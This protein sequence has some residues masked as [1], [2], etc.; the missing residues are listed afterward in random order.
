MGGRDF[1]VSF[2]LLADDVP[3]RMRE[4]EGRDSQAA[5]A[6]ASVRFFLPSFPVLSLFLGSATCGKS[7]GEKQEGERGKRLQDGPGRSALSLFVG[8]CLTTR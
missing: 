2:I 3:S 7:G 4:G 5:G 8:A 6:V 1:L